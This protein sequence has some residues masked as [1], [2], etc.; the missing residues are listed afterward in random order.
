MFLTPR[1]SDWSWMNFRLKPEQKKNN[2][3]PDDSDVYSK[4]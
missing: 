3:S 1:K 4:L 2:L